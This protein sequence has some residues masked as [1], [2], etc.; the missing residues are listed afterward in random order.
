MFPV[1]VM[2]IGEGMAPNGAAGA[3]AVS[4]IIEADAVMAVV[5]DVKVETAPG[6]GDRTGAGT[7]AIEG[8]GGGGTAN[9]AGTGMIEPG[10]TVMADVSGCWENVNGG[11]T[12]GGSTD[13]VGA[14]ET[15]GVVPMVVPVADAEGAMEI[16]VTVGVPGVI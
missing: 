8:N 10:K 16:T 11:I 15:D 6:T 4:G 7:G 5:P 9:V 1:V 3:I 2:T 13:V 14:A 12:I